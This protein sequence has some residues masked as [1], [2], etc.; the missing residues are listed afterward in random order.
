MAVVVFSQG[1]VGTELGW[2][3]GLGGGLLAAAVVAML[4]FHKL[5]WV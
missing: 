5:D 2:F 1:V 4:L 3:L